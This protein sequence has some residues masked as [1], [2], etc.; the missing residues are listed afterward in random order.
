MEKTLNENR[1]KVPV[2]ALSAV[3]AAIAVVREAVKAELLPPFE[4]KGRA[5]PVTVFRL[6]EIVA[7]DASTPRRLGVPPSTAV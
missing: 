2:S 7:Q 1:T 3:D 6:L 4:F 5:E